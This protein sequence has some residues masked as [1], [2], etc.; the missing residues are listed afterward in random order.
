MRILK[1]IICLR[2]SAGGYYIQGIEL[3]AIG[4]FRG[5]HA[6]FAKA[7]QGDPNDLSA[8]DAQRLSEDLLGGVIGC[9]TALHLFK[10]AALGNSGCHARALDEFSAALLWNRNYHRAHMGMSA[11]HFCCRDYDQA[12]SCLIRAIELAP[13][14]PIAHYTLGTVY[15]AKKNWK[16]AI[17]EY[18]ASRPF[19]KTPAELKTKLRRRK[20]HRV[21]RQVFVRYGTVV[22]WYKP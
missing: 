5:A 18:S 11:Q 20:L 13:G 3:G 12:I 21:V 22:Q 9:Q 14:D 4:D 10:G 1:H 2:A 8:Q 17:Q 6:A 19:A 7:V 15:T 16:T